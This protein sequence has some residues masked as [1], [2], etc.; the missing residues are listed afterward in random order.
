MQIDKDLLQYCKDK[1]FPVEEMNAKDFK[2][3][4]DTLDFQHYK[5]SLKFKKI[6]KEV[7][8]ALKQ[9][10]HRKKSCKNFK[11]K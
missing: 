4:E 5:L 1:E 6:G 10:E 8:N 7:L 3:V 2:A 9:I 11:C